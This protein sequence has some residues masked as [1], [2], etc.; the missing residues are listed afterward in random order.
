MAKI[1]FVFSGQGAQYS[2]MG[3][4][5]YQCSQS[6]KSVFDAAEGIRP[7]TICQCFEAG[8]EELSITIN[9]QPCVYLVDLAAAMALKEQGIMPNAVAG[10]SLGEIAALAFSGAFSYDNAFRLVVARA[11]FM[12]E[13]S[14]NTRGA[15]AA[16]L[17][18]DD[19]QIISLCSKIKNVYP[20][21][22]NSP[23]QIVVSGHKDAVSEFI[24]EAKNMG[25]RAVPL[26]V[27][28]AFHSPLMSPAAEK[29]A[30]VFNSFKPQE[31]RLPVYTNVT[32]R[33]YPEDIKTLLCEQT[34]KPVLWQKTIENMVQ[35]GID[36]FIEV[37]PGKTLCGLIK[38]TVAG[39]RVYNVEDELSL[40]STINALKGE[41]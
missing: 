41:N 16:V 30:Q 21:N 19:Q 29:L 39:V 6:A 15:M 10:F 7:G 13:A 26:A 5:L 32:A 31:P 24:K 37:G 18:L 8:K 12:H 35:D 38:K 33:P 40:K 25:G 34:Q 22:Y 27:S 17:K 9:T 2:G 4:S 14:Q 23:G 20:A 28:G 11:G 1:A 3:K 36:T